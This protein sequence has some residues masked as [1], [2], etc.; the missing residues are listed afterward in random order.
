M[1][2]PVVT[3]D[4]EWWRSW[5]GW[6]V[7]P[8]DRQLLVEAAAWSADVLVCACSRER[9]KAL[10]EAERLVMVP[11]FASWL[12]DGVA[13]SVLTASGVRRFGFVTRCLGERCGRSQLLKVDVRWRG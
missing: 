2:D 11:V 13:R 6:P 3:L 12:S 5:R 10:P 1:T 8:V 7:Q 9:F 4:G